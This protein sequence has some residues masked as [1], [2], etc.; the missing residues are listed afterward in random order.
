[1]QHATRILKNETKVF[2]QGDKAKLCS[3]NQPYR[4]ED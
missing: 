4:S 1:M 3:N 2:K